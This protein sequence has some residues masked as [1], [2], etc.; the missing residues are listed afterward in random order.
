MDTSIGIDWY[1]Y[2]HCLSDD[3]M[4]ELATWLASESLK[5]SEFTDLVDRVYAQASD[6]WRGKPPT[7]IARYGRPM[8]ERYAQ[9]KRGFAEHLAALEDAY[10]SGALPGDV[11]GA[12]LSPLRPPGP[13]ARSMDEVLSVLERIRSET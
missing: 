5:V 6:E 3:Q 13:D 8:V 9:R 4:R 10:M 2:L 11:L 12:E 1:D 7:F